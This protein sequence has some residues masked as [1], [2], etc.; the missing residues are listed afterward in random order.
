MAGLARG[1]SRRGFLFSGFAAALL[2]QEKPGAS[3]PSA[4]KRYSD[5]TT[6]LDVYRLTDPSYPSTLPAAYNRAIAHNNAWML[7]CCDRNGSPQAFRLDLKS[8]ETRELTTV[9]DLDGSSLTLTPDNRSFCFFAGRSLFLS[10]LGGRPREL[11]KIP[12]GW[13]RTA[14]LSVGPDGTHATFAERQAGGSRLRM[15]PLAQAAARTVTESPFVISHPIARPMRAQILF[16]QGDDALWLVNSDGTQKHQLKFATGRVGPA[17]WA[18]DGKTVLYL[19]FPEDSKQLTAIRECNPDAASDQLVAKTSQFAH[20]GFNRDTSV[21]VGASR[22][23]ASPTILLLLRVTQR[24]LTLCEHKASHP[25]T[26]APR[27]SP[28]AQRVYFQ[29]DR[30]GKPAIYCM[31]VERLVEKIDAESRSGL[32]GAP[33]L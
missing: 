13:E 25:E 32:I 16:R 7:F 5:P 9:E 3:F 33:C 20:F 11:Y 24:E 6:E 12:E 8:G 18:P 17:D 27:F 23:A 14:G 1:F 22:S 19:N 21:F 2:A 29:S 28:D 4:V 15:V 10:G 30:D 31:H 26:T